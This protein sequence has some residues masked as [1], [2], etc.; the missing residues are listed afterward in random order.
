ME[1]LKEFRGKL[2]SPKSG[3]TKTKV[4]ELEMTSAHS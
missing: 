1:N 4:Y 3:K 2:K